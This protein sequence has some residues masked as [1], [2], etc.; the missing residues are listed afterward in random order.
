MAS[1]RIYDIVVFGATGYTGRCAA[2]HVF[3]TC[4]TNLSWAVAGRSANK[5]GDIVTKLQKDHPDRKHPGEF[6][7]FG[8]EALDADISR[9]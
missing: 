3:K 1:D 7:T 2:E 4:P 8:R 6:E 5:L 9:Y